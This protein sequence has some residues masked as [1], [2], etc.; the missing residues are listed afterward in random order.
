MHNMSWRFFQKKKTA[1]HGYGVC[2][3]YGTI[4]G[5]NCSGVLSYKYYLS[6]GGG[7]EEFDATPAHNDSVASILS[8]MFSLFV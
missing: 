5:S 1:L 6:P 3:K 2:P 7:S 4:T 8:S